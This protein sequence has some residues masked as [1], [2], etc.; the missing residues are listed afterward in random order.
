[1]FL[2]TTTRQDA[3]YRC[4]LSLRTLQRE[5]SSPT[6]CGESNILFESTRDLL[7]QCD[8]TRIKKN[9]H[10]APTLN[11]SFHSSPRRRRGAVLKCVTRNGEVRVR[12]PRPAFLIWASYVFAILF[13]RV[14]RIAS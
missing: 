14:A 2:L 13:G 3:R 11:V 12:N 1:M 4:K 9:S 7:L 5:T 10:S 6:A 8:N